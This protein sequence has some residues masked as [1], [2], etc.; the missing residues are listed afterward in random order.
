MI[1]LKQ[2]QQSELTAF[3]TFSV[4]PE[5]K[6]SFIEHMHKLS[7]QGKTPQCTSIMFLTLPD[8]QL[9]ARETDVLKL[10]ASG[11]SNPEIAGF[12]HVTPNT[13]KTHVRN[14]MTKLGVE[15]RTQLAVVAVILDQLN[16]SEP[17][18]ASESQTYP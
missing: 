17:T 12:L 8:Y 16:Y 14:L 1:F 9:S 15:R 7:A 11:F 2:Q 13:I 6:Q 5:Q 10:V 4:S 3:V 18:Q